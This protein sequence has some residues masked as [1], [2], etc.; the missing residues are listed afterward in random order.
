MLYNENCIIVL[1]YWVGYIQTL[2][3]NVTSNKKS[4]NR[5]ELKITSREYDESDIFLWRRMDSSL[6]TFSRWLQQIL[7]WLDRYKTA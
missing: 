6:N 7:N 1:V 4:R 2:K 5:E 3:Q